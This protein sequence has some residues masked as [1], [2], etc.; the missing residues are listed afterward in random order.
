MA[1]YQRGGKCVNIVVQRGLLLVVLL[2]LVDHVQVEG[3]LLDLVLEQ[4]VTSP[5][6]TI[7]KFVDF[8]FFFLEKKDIRQ[9][10]ECKLDQL[11]NQFITAEVN[12]FSTQLHN[13]VLR[14]F[15]KGNVAVNE[16]VGLASLKGDRYAFESSVD[17]FVLF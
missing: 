15:A 8:E 13:V 7:L 6:F 16:H 11:K 2:V 12:Q 10:A 17:R 1:R 9:R 3:H 4:G 14:V 5:L